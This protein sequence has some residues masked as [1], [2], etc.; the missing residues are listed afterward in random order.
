[1]SQKKM[2]FLAWCI[3]DVHVLL[4]LEIWQK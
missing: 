3:F 1:M 2:T 4:I